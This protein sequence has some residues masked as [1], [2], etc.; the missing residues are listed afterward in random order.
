VNFFVQVIAA[1]LAL[2]AVASAGVVH[3]PLAYSAVVAPS[4]ISRA[5]QFDSAVIKSDRLGG[6]FAYSV[7]ENHAYAQH[8]PV[9]QHVTSAVGVSY[10]AGA[11]VVTGYSA[12]V[13]RAVSF[14]NFA[15]CW[16]FLIMIF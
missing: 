16:T 2:A 3:A 12:P 9:V 14:I 1:L 13:V 7:A 6:N 11:P 8:T 15:K 10:S 5:P 4:I